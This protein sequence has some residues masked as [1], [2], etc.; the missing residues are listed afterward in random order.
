MWGEVTSKCWGWSFA[1]SPKGGSIASIGNTGLGY[2]TIGD[3]PDPPDEI[4][5]SVPDGCPE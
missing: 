3:G 4:P 2:G 5:D 1:S